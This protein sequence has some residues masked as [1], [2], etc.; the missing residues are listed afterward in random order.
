MLCPGVK[1]DDISC[2][3]PVWLSG[4]DL[5]SQRPAEPALTFRITL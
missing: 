4:D 2:G 3:Q 5:V 1:T